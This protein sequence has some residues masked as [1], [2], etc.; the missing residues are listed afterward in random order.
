MRKFSV[1]LSLWRAGVFLGLS[2]C[3]VSLHAEL[4]FL[5][6]GDVL[7]GRIVSQTVENVRIQTA[8]SSR[9]VS[10]GDIARISYDSE[11][12]RLWL[13]GQEREKR[14]RAEMERVRAEVE[15]MRAE[16]LRR[17][18][19]LKT[20]EEQLGEYQTR[21]ADA[22]WRSL[23][24]PGWGQYY[25][26]E[27]I[28]GSL[29]AGG[30]G[31]MLFQLYRANQEYRDASAA[32]DQA[33]ALSLASAA[34]ANAGGIA[35]AYAFANE[36][37][38]TK[39]TAAARGNL[40]LGLFAAWYVYNVIDAYITGNRYLQPASSPRIPPPTRSDPPAESGESGDIA[41]DGSEEPPSESQPPA[42]PASE[43]APEANLFRAAEQ[44]AVSLATPS[45]DR[46]RVEIPIAFAWTFSF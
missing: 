39:Q 8:D 17:E 31:L 22:W 44:E 5:K 40:I 32:F 27:T 28:K 41:P 18:Q 16:T 2:L 12:E 19:E 24:W 43:A 45:F 42:T 30:A 26:G 3:S 34:T 15:Q 38:N 29:I 13:E 23:V 11:E 33:S 20:R 21:L 37:R 25:R 10:K 36:A 35:G 1:R 46:D 7:Q 9:L 14:E 4:V 6:S